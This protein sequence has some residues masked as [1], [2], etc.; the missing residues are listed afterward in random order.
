[1]SQM[2]SFVLM[3]SISGLLHYCLASSASDALE[4]DC[5]VRQPSSAAYS[6]V[7]TVSISLT[8]PLRT[9]TLTW[10][11]CT[12]Y[13]TAPKS[14]L[15]SPA[16]S[17][18]GTDKDDFLP[19]PMSMTFIELACSWHNRTFMAAVTNQVKTISP[20]RA[21]I[22]ELDE[23]NDTTDPVDS[24]VI[25][26]VRQQLI[27]LT[28]H[29]CVTQTVTSK[30]Y[31]IGNFPYLVRLVMQGCWGL[32]IRKKDLENMQQ[33]RMV[34]FIAATIESMEPYT[35]TNLRNLRSLRLEDQ[36][37]YLLKQKGNPID[38]LYLDRSKLIADEDVERITSLHCN[39]SLAWFRNFL[40]AKPF[41][42][43][44]KRKGEDYIVG[45]FISDTVF[46]DGIYGSVL[47]VDCA[48]KVSI[49]NVDAGPQFS[50]NTSCYNIKC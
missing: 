29:H 24:N 26:P 47:N 30:I 9:D 50:Y 46:V 35:F 14:F 13:T 38:Q 44:E 7:N 45:N 32:I 1:M 42:T 18:N 2:T 22:M 21:V 3:L 41:L 4:T 6:S 20:N 36:L 43:A 31:K 40:R 10:E 25:E 15:C 27:S 19:P 33:L 11:E 5:N 34:Q 8:F 23:K 28:V 49:H 48:K 37:R 39:C 12:A 16:H 17:C